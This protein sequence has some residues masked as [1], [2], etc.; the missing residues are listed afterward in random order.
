MFQVEFHL[1]RKENMKENMKMQLKC[2]IMLLKYI[3]YV[4][5]LMLQEELRYFLF[6][7]FSSFSI[8]SLI[9]SKKKSGMQIW[10]I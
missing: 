10:E 9:V 7:I 3:P 1:Q 5:K 6:F 8:F 2:I 4:L